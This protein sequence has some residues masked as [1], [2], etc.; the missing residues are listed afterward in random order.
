MHGR[1]NTSAHERRTTRK[2]N[3][4]YAKQR[5]TQK[6]MKGRQAWRVCRQR[7]LVFQADTGEGQANGSRI[8]ARANTIAATMP[9]MN[10]LTERGMV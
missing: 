4:G 2:R 10:Q 1:V 6:E 5:Q 8:P 7:G 3:C 9:S